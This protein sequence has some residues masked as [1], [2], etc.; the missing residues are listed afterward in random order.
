MYIIWLLLLFRVCQSFFAVTFHLSAGT[1]TT[2][3]T[4][5]AAA[6]HLGAADGQR[7]AERIEGPLLQRGHLLLAERQV[8]V[9][10][11]GADEVGRLP[12]QQVLSQLFTNCFLIIRSYQQHLLR[13]CRLL[14]RADH[15]VGARVG[16]ATVPVD[17][18]RQLPGVR[19]V[20]AV[21]GQAVEEEVGL[22]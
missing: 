5:A 10:E 12:V 17:G 11:R 22:G 21:L 2:T 20:L 4:G 3:S 15:R 7:L 13:R 19:L 9:L 16:G 8:E 14:H 6:A 18:L 1:A